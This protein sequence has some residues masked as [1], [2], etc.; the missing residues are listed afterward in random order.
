M[1]GKNKCL[2]VLVRLFAALVFLF[3]AALLTYAVWFAIKSSAF[4]LPSG[5]ALG[6]GFADAVMGIVL[7]TCGYKIL[8]ALRTF[9]LIN[10]L[11]FIA[12]LVVTVLLFLPSTRASIISDA[13]LIDPV[14]TFVN[15]NID[16]CC[17]VLT[18]AM[19]VKLVAVVLVSMQTCVLSRGFD[20][21]E[22]DGSAALIAEEGGIE[23]AAYSRYGAW[24]AL[25]RYLSRP[26]MR[27]GEVSRL[28]TSFHAP[29]SPPFCLFSEEKNKSVYEKYGLGSSRESAFRR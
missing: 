13:Q 15:D 4:L 9:L 1:S 11:L 17:Y 8:C 16:V 7:L 6:L 24:G 14:A 21:S 25:L 23:A 12:E 18:A 28:H 10:G 2:S 27:P 5:V 19:G 29:I 26:H 22:Y 3:G 20:D